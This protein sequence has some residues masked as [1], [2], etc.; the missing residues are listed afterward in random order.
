MKLIVDDMRVI[1]WYVDTLFIVHTD[2]K[3]HKS[4]TMIYGAG[5]TQYSSMRQKLNK[6]STTERKVVSVENMA[7]NILWEIPY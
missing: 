7:L 1:N 3:I 2:F 4:G 5:A 6:I